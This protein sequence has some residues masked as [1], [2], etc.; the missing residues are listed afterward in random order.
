MYDWN[1]YRNGQQSYQ[2]SQR[3]QQQYF[4]QQY[5]TYSNGNPA[6]IEEYRWSSINNLNV[7]C[8]KCDKHEHLKME[9]TNSALSAEEQEH[10]WQETMK[11][12][13][14]RAETRQG[15]DV[16]QESSR[17]YSDSQAATTAYVEAREYAW[18]SLNEW[19]LSN[20]DTHILQS[21]SIEM[22]SVTDANSIDAYAAVD[23]KCSVKD[24]GLEETERGS[25]QACSNNS[26]TYLQRKF[27]RAVRQQQWWLTELKEEM[28]LNITK[29]L[30]NKIILLSLLQY[31]NLNPQRKT[32][33]GCA[34]KLKS[35]MIMFTTTG[36][37]VSTIVST[38]LSISKQSWFVKQVNIIDESW[39]DQLCIRLEQNHCMMKVNAVSIVRWLAKS[40]IVNFYIKTSIFSRL[41][42][43]T[44]FNLQKTLIDRDSALNLIFL[45]VV[46]Q[47]EITQIS[48]DSVIIKVTNER[49]TTLITYCQFKMMVKGV[50]EIIETFVI[51]RNISYFLL[52]E[53][54]WMCVITVIKDYAYDDYWISDRNGNEVRLN[55]IRVSTSVKIMKVKLNSNVKS[56]TPF[57]EETLQN[58]KAEQHD[59]AD[60]IL[61]EVIKEAEED[62]ENEKEDNNSDSEKEFSKNKI[63]F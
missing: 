31:A 21:N 48:D 36:S 50:S 62:T 46:K 30:N 19:I 40:S 51:S 7:Q 34:L 1:N 35:K 13:W 18:E 63:H 5:S 15:E 54:S 26:V 25:S 45:S 47:T 57:N 55:A 8:W 16:S 4:Q 20:R 33:I 3:S 44:I 42:S 28:K 59:I 39:E 52:L 49:K 22:F 6:M 12:L 38:A 14:A 11:W 17:Q 29:I 53:C 23:N 27:T 2:G 10:I 41:S 37:W 32:A 58:L 43:K 56:P 9:C 24:V 60:I 61:N